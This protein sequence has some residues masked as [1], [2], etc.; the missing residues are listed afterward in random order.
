[1]TQ[2][3]NPG[4]AISSVHRARARGQTDILAALVNDYIDKLWTG[5]CD[6]WP[7]LFDYPDGGGLV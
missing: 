6:S 3:N 4:D 1:M 7:D 5:F 2:W